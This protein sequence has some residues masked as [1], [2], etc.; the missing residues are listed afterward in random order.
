MARVDWISNDTNSSSTWS[1]STGVPTTVAIA[2]S[3]IH[4]TLVRLARPTADSRCTFSSGYGAVDQHPPAEH[5]DGV[6]VADVQQCL[7]DRVPRHHGLRLGGQRLG[8]GRELGGL[9]LGQQGTDRGQH[10]VPVRARFA[11]G[12]RR[13]GRGRRA[14]WGR[15][16]GRGGRWLLGAPGGRRRQRPGQRGQLLQPGEQA[17]RAGPGRQ[18]GHVGHHEPVDGQPVGTRGPDADVGRAGSIGRGLELFPPGRRREVAALGSP[19]LLDRDV[20]GQRGRPL[21]DP[22][23]DVDQIAGLPTALPLAARTAEQT[24]AG[25]LVQPGEHLPGEAAQ[26][27]FDQPGEAARAGLGRRPER[28]PVEVEAGLVVEVPGTG[29]IRSPLGVRGRQRIA[30]SRSGHHRVV[31]TELPQQVVDELRLRRRRSR[32]CRPTPGPVPLLG[33]S[34]LAAVAS[35]GNSQTAR[36]DTRCPRSPARG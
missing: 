6:A 7:V 35:H 33:G 4:T 26:L 34:S 9:G 14:G 32:W 8:L 13:P 18:R 5:L 25:H 11:W 23:G 31:V 3:S 10:L 16:A 24:R 2:R 20:G 27:A 17:D 36:T 29:T 12:R 19:D 15:R 22:S 21:V 30:A 28:Q 1:T